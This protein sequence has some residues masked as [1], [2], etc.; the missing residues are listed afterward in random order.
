VGWVRH[1]LNNVRRLKAKVGGD[2]FTLRLAD[3]S[4][5]EFTAQD[6]LANFMQNAQRLRAYHEGRAI[7]P[8]HRLGAAL[9]MAVNRTPEQAEA[10]EA[11]KRLDAQLSQSH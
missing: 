10:A 7:P 2:S 8:P 1:N 6:C 11:Q 3:G 5:E 4:E 9:P